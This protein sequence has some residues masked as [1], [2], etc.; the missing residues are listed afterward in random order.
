M[1]FAEILTF[2]KQGYAKELAVGAF[3]QDFDLSFGYDEEF[4]AVFVLFDEVL[5]QIK[6]DELEFLGQAIHDVLVNVR[7][8]WNASERFGAEGWDAV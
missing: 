4:L 5:A 7:E 6:V 1:C 2:G 8:K 3:A